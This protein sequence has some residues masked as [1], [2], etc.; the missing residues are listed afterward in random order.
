MHSFEILQ[1]KKMETATFS[2]PANELVTPNQLIWKHINDPAHVVTEDD[3]KKMV[4]GKDLEDEMKK[5]LN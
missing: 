2:F 3:F 5:R 4:I 1:K